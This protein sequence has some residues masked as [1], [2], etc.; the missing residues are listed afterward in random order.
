[1]R[2]SLFGLMGLAA[3]A[4][5][6]ARADLVASFGSAYMGFRDY[7]DRVVGWDFTT[8]IT[9]L[10]LTAL[11]FYDDGADGLQV[12]HRVG[13]YRTGTT[14]LVA[15]ATI[16]AGTGATLNGRFREVSIGPAVALDPNTTYTVAAT[17]PALTDRFINEEEHVVGGLTI[18]PHVTA[19][20]LPS[21]YL[22]GTAT[23]AFPTNQLT[24]DSRNFFFGGNAGVSTVPEPGAAVLLIGGALILAVRRRRQ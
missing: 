24:G 20:S 17:V 12:S 14:Q 11:S 4:V 1:M 15:S 21:R 10:Y 2:K 22:F 19:G 7:D 16:G 23:L 5:M 9:P 3:A 13:V 6:T 8:G 18:D